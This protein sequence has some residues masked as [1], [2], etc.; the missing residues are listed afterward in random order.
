MNAD[1]QP[2]P[3]PSLLVRAARAATSSALASAADVVV[4]LALVRT[5][6]VKVGLAAA[7]GCLAGGTVNFLITRRW[8]FR[9]RTPGPA[10]ARRTLQQMAL[11][12]LLIV[13]GGAVLGGAVI[14]VA[15]ALLAMSMLGAKLLAAALVFICWNYPVSALVVFKKEPLV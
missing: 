12:G 4:L 11:Y 6:H 7:L 13:L 3:R 10:S 8:V 15:V 1:N 9:P 14:H 5:A 2:Q